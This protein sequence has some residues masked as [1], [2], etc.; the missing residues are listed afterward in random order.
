[1]AT[2][3]YGPE[4]C[5]FYFN[6]CNGYVLRAG[7]EKSPGASKGQALR[8]SLPTSR[9]ARRSQLQMGAIS[10]ACVSQTLAGLTLHS[11]RRGAGVGQ[12]CIRFLL[13]V[14]FYFFKLFLFALWLGKFPRR[15][16]TDDETRK[17]PTGSGR[18][19]AGGAKGAGDTGRGREKTALERGRGDTPQPASKPGHSAK[20]AGRAAAA[21]G[22]GESHGRAGRR[23][24]PELPG[25]G[26]PP[27]PTSGGGNWSSGFCLRE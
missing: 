22:E 14:F 25:G 20:R 27:R 4:S 9:S 26:G 24:K 12:S 17:S 18:G 23:G 21:A 16:G 13:W 10:P 2:W 3:W 5:I 7:S 1:M 6:I 19:G 8:F 15:S 11:Q